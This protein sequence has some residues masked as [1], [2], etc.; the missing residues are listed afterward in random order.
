MGK[1]NRQRRAAKQRERRRASGFDRNH[2]AGAGFDRDGF[3]A[4]MAASVQAAVIVAA[5]SHA[6][7]NADAARDCVHQLVGPGSPIG[8]A[9]LG[10]VIESL[11]SDLVDAVV[12]A[13]GW[14]PADLQQ[15]VARKL[16]PAHLPLL[17]AAL[18][19]QAAAHPPSTVHPRWTAQLADLG[20]VPGFLSMLRAGR[21]CGLDELATLT[22]AVELLGLLTTTPELVAVLPPPGR[23][24]GAVQEIS[25]AEA[26]VLARVRAL[27]SKAEST[28]FTEEAEA[29]TAKAQDLMTRHSLEQLV[30][31]RDRG[32]ADPVSAARLWLDAPYAS[33]KSLMA[34][35]VS[36]ANRCRA[37]WADALGCMTIIGRAADLAAVELL[38]TSLLVQA[39]KS[40]LDG[41]PAT[42]RRTR[43]YRQSF[44]VAFAT[45][46]GE[47]LRGTASTASNELDENSA[48]ELLPVLRA[49]SERVE[50]AFAE[51]FPH[52]VSRSVSISNGVGWAAG[53]A[54][55]DLALLD[56]HGQVMSSA[57]PGLGETA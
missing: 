25:Q 6:A 47:R 23:F 16:G 57:N 43:S 35:V 32:E 31:Q 19:T 49:A 20:A 48:G 56:V 13:A 36:E 15:F 5:G 2:R 50:Q 9:A 14:Q 22:F 34:H 53:R 24:A 7:G 17:A 42:G 3:A 37:V 52:T 54:A 45:R 12:S 26:R 55:A 41:H 46:I 51:A 29:L 38:T 10:Q 33:A 18:A 11:L 27:L 4:D 28:E 8:A 39:T 1:N 44:L 21:R 40:M 30:A